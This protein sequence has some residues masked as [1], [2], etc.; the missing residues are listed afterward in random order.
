MTDAEIRLGICIGISVLVTILFLRARL[1]LSALPRIRPVP[2]RP[3]LD[4]MVVI[5]ARDEEQN[6]ARAVA[7]FPHDTVIV[8]D[9][10]SSDATAEIAQKAGAGVLKAPPLPRGAM[11][12]PAACELGALPLTSRWV[13]FAD[14]DTWYEK[15]FLDAMV[16]CAEASK[17]AFLSAHLTLAPS[18]LAENLLAP[19]AVA[20]YYS[21]VNSKREPAAGFNGQ[22]ILV[23]R[24]A[25][26]FIGGHGALR[27]YMVEDVKL[28][29][30][31]ERHRLQFGLVR[32]GPL[33]H[34]RFHQGFSGIGDG[35]ERNAFRFAE[36]SSWHGLSILLTA[37]SAAL[38]LPMAAWLWFNEQSE[39]AA[40]VAILPLLWLAGWY[41]SW[42]VVLAPIATYVMLPFVVRGAISA[43][44]GAKVEWKGRTI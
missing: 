11:G 32:S 2:P 44:S 13:L 20:L 7:S 39:A 35:I 26:F 24:E 25:Y 4:C 3:A 15:G 19:Y 30:L 34:M 38:W 36:L 33:G 31:A 23:Q 9:D 17:V 28:A 21:G 14:A 41:R 5:P 12:K 27:K 6:I 29:R 1:H 42:R 10:G 16:S 8:V 40:I 22:C 18:G 43:L 37:F